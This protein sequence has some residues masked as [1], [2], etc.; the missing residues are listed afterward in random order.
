MWAGGLLSRGQSPTPV[1]PGP[2][3]SLVRCGIEPFER[4]VPALA[5]LTR[6]A[7]ERD[8]EMHAVDVPAVPGSVGPDLDVEGF[9]QVLSTVVIAMLILNSAIKLGN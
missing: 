2:G 6:P 8:L 4:D 9:Q 3:R 7:A 1:R 5:L